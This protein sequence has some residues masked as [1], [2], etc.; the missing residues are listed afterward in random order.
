MC[1]EKGRHRTIVL[2]QVHYLI[3]K[4]T[5]LTPHVERPPNIIKSKGDEND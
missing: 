3:D 5:F 2:Q 4:E 1:V